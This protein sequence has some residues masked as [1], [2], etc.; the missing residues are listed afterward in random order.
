MVRLTQHDQIENVLDFGE[1]RHTVPRGALIFVMGHLDEHEDSL[2]RFVG[3][4]EG[5]LLR[6]YLFDS[7]VKQL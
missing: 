4:Y 7:E 3:L 5:N 2:H 6:F 1:T